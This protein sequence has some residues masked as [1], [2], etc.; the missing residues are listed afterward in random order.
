[1][2]KKS[3]SI[4]RPLFGLSGFLVFWLNETNQMNQISQI[5][6]TNQ[7]NQTDRACPRRAGHPSF[8]VLKWLFR[9]LLVP[10]A[11]NID[12]HILDILIGQDVLPFSH[13]SVGPSLMHRANKLGSE[14]RMHLRRR[15]IRNRRIERRI[16]ITLSGWPMTGGT[17]FLK[18]YL[19]WVENLSR[20]WSLSHL[21]NRM[22]AHP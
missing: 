17:V 20:S 19:A 21:W 15:E 12:D 4:R 18:G 5:N 2:L 3:A 7:I 14:L 16:A 10:Q 6:K 13:R 11:A 1:V 9:S 8:A 22:T